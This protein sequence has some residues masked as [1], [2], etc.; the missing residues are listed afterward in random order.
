MDKAK[1]Q[2]LWAKLVLEG[3][4]NAEHLIRAFFN[5][6]HPRSSIEIKGKEAK[7][8][9]IFNEPPYRI[10]EA[11]T[12]CKV[13]GFYY[14]D[15]SGDWVKFET[16]QNESAAS[17]QA[18]EVTEV[19]TEVV[20]PEEVAE[21][22]T[23]VVV[24][25]EVTEVATEVVAPE[26]VTE[27]VTEA[28][29]TEEGAEVIPGLYEVVKKSAS[30]KDF[31]Y[32]VA[33]WLEINGKRELFVKALEVATKL[34]KPTWKNIALKLN[35]QEI[36]CTQSDYISFSKKCSSKFKERSNDVTI[37]K[38]I[39]GIVA[40]K[41]FNFCN[42]GSQ[43]VPK[44]V[45]TQKVPRKRKEES[46]ELVKVT[47]EQEIK[48]PVIKMACMPAI[49]WFEKK[50]KEMDRNLPIEAKVGYVLESMG[51]GARKLQDQQT[52]LR[53]VDEAMKLDAKDFNRFLDGRLKERMTFVSFINE[54]VKLHDSN[55]KVRL[56]DFLKDLKE[57]VI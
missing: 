5:E 53:I 46:P 30:Y 42:Q 10:I 40:Y 22:A 48:Q 52:I 37:M 56:Q 44:L 19:A 28:V 23:E 21:V 57:I 51:L 26:E 54:F 38:L 35:S 31:L 24:P 9:I 12:F 15:A 29:A 3:Q 45:E 7:L 16:E 8:K 1:E 13:I 34:E 33:K 2:I 6:F 18:E 25:E 39:R 27:V 43:S 20:A 11:I 4:K 17:N 41:E 49:P 32:N 36:K 50:L 14:G 55:K 47:A